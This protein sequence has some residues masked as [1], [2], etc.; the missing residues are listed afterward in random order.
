MKKQSYAAK[1]TPF[2]SLKNRPEEAVLLIL[3]YI[4]TYF[5]IFFNSFFKKSCF[6]HKKVNNYL[7]IFTLKSGLK[8]K[9][10]GKS[11]KNECGS[12]LTAQN[13][14]SEIDDNRSALARLLC[15]V[16]RKTSFGAYHHGNGLYLSEL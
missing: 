2:F 9:M 12:R 3:Y 14:R 1:R 7:F 16:E 8:L 6:F 10:V 13:S 15:L 11:R 5:L 4:V